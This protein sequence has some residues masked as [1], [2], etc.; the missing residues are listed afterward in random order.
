MLNT[1]PASEGRPSVRYKY[2]D[3]PVALPRKLKLYASADTPVNDVVPVDSNTSGCA[4]TNPGTKSL[5]PACTTPA[6]V[7]FA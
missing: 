1:L 3:E 5:F 6:N 2:P 7:P 4:S